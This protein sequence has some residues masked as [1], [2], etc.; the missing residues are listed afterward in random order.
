MA[1]RYLK[2]VAIAGLLTPS[3]TARAL[4]SVTRFVGSIRRVFVPEE[5]PLGR[6]GSTKHEFKAKK[7][8]FHDACSQD[9]CYT[10]EH[11][12]ATV[13]FVS[14][15]SSSPPP[16]TP[17]ITPSPAVIAPPTLN[18]TTATPPPRPRLLS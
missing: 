3:G 14:P 18:V 8:W 4:A 16:P 10:N 9:H 17:P 7:V 15:P 2:P 6:W 13:K 1:S 5:P 12:L 11:H